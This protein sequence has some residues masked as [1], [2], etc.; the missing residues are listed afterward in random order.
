MMVQ[1][2]DDTS[3]INF[4]PVPL[5]LVSYEEGANGQVDNVYRRMRMK[6]ESI[7]RQWPDAKM[8]Q[9]SCSALS[10]TSQPMMS[11]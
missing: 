8:S 10:T 9:T 7:S 11:S 1:P 6:A 2:G 5:F 4:V 3:P